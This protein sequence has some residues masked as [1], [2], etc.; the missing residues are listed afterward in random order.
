MELPQKIQDDIWEYCRLN[1]ITDI[2]AFT[3]KMVKQGFTVEKYGATPSEKI[4]EK[5]VEKI[6]E[7]EKEV[8]KIV[9]VIKEV[10][11]EKIVE[12]KVTDDEGLQKFVD[13]IGEL[14]GTIETKQQTINSLN[15]Q[16]IES[17]SDNGKLKEGLASAKA[18]LERQI[19]EAKK[20]LLLINSELEA[21]KAKP[22]EQ[23]KKDIYG[24][25]KKGFYGSNTRENG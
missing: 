6:V 17:R 4:V 18:E 16:L 2:D 15:L 12:V 10:P 7:V 5:E 23:T 13:E 24:E 20:E 22:K 11:V 8:E 19:V 14:K 9:E 21:E 25:G 1:K 3:L